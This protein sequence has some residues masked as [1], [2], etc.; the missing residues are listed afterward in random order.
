MRLQH[1]ILCVKTSQHEQRFTRLVKALFHFKKLSKET[2]KFAL[3][4]NEFKLILMSS[5]LI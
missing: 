5:Q 3:K 4:T 2:E 1:L